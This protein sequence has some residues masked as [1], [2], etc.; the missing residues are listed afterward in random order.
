MRSVILPVDPG[1]WPTYFPTNGS[2]HVLDPK[3][4][5]IIEKR[6]PVVRG[7][8][9]PCRVADLTPSSSSNTAYVT[10]PATS[11]VHSVDLTTGK[12]PKSA[13]LDV[14]PNEITI[15]LRSALTFLNRVKRQ[16]PHP[17]ERGTVASRCTR[18]NVFDWRPRPFCIKLIR[19]LR[20]T[21]VHRQQQ[22]WAVARLVKHRHGMQG[23]RV[24]GSPLSSTKTKKPPVGWFFVSG[25]LAASCRSKSGQ[26]ER[27]SSSSAPPGRWTRT[28]F[29]SMIGLEARALDAMYSR[30]TLTLGLVSLLALIP[31]GL[32]PTHPRTQGQRVVP[33]QRPRR[34]GFRCAGLKALTISPG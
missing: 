18:I 20:G 32:E 33:A 1:I 9:R 3:D 22:F 30:H 17:A 10:E 34:R 11:T 7:L 16:V 25:D 27:R 12:V 15:T 24:R 14:V 19:L 5:K 21:R 29:V 23:V 31:V 8:G 26:S 4:G 6:I 28:R 13:K 2:I